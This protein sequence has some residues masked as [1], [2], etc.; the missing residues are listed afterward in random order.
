M[1]KLKPILVK[2]KRYHFWVVI[3]L[4]LGVAVGVWKTS[5]GGLQGEKQSN[6]SRIKDGFNK[7]GLS[8]E[9]DVGQSDHPNDHFKAGMDELIQERTEQVLTAWQERWNQQVEAGIL[10]WPP[11]L[12]P[13]FIK[14]VEKLRPI[15]QKVPF[16][17]PDGQE[18]RSRFREDYRDYI[19]QELPQLAA[20]IGS[21]WKAVDDA[22]AEAASPSGG[23]LFGGGTPAAAPDTPTP[24][25]D[26]KLI[27]VWNGT[28]QKKI[29]QS[30]FDWSHRRDGVPTTLDVLYA[31]EDLWVLDSLMRIIQKTNGSATARHNAVIR[32]IDFIEFGQDVKS[33]AGKIHL[34]NKN[35]PG[36][37]PAGGGGSAAGGLHGGGGGGAPTASGADPGD[38]RCVDNNYQPLPASTLRGGAESA[39]LEQ[40]YLAVARRIPVRMKLVMDHRKIN[41]LLIEC[42]NSPLTVEV[43]QLRMHPSTAAGEPGEGGKGSNDFPYDRNVELYGI[44]YIYNPVDHDRLGVEAVEPAAA[45]EAAGEAADG[46]SDA[47]DDGAAAE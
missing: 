16:P 26:D 23:G 14:E 3:V 41:R 37:A 5:V 11:E 40:A 13:E 24:E 10:E 43:R 19:Q 2:I 38:G 28:N 35:G 4:V 32:Y 8:G 36:K 39:D 12:G 18:I 20:M 30:S 31:Q 15:E 29:L 46:P 6:L 47:A 1:D 34:V 9:G 25:A 45:E 27:V 42:A 17:T 33:G 22:P 21:E 44:V 7:I